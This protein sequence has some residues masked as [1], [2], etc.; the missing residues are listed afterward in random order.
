MKRILLI[1]IAGVLGVSAHAQ[2]PVALKVGVTAVR[3]R[4]YSGPYAKYS[5]K[6]L[7]VEAEQS[8]SVAT[9]LTSVK[10]VPRPVSADELS[11]AF[12]KQQRKKADFSY[13]P[14]LKSS[15][16]QR[17]IELSAAKAADQ[18]IDIRQKRYQILTGD[19]DMSLSAESLSLT[20]NE[21]A[22]QEAELMKLFFGYTI[23]E[24]L[25][26][27]FMVLPKAGE[28][29]HLYVAFRIS[30]NGLL[31]AEHLEGRMVTIELIP[32]NVP[33]TVE[34]SVASKK[35][36]KKAPKGFRW[37]AKSEFVPAE[38]VLK[39]RDGANVILQGRVVIPQLG[40]ERVFDELVPVEKK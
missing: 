23:T 24:E 2:E 28:D 13:V 36:K 6:Y 11:F 8:S 16:G 12:G 1:F 35:K 21:F 20:L 3:E 4:F 30:E 29:S 40:H 10:V 17:S 39:M 14:L 32:D 25:E 31:P 26:G 5:V 38:C 33:E 27:E 34:T 9:T 18:I 19:T 7:G 15:V 22:R 37:E